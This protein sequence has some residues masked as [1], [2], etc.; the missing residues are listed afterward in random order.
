MNRRR[1]VMIAAVPVLGIAGLAT[2]RALARRARVAHA[3]ALD[4]ALA[5]R[6]ERYA[7]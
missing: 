3:R 1:L 6:Y 4:Y 7:G 2:W 5:E